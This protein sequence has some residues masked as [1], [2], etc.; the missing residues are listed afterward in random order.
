MSPRNT[1]IFARKILWPG[2]NI[3]NRHH[4]L[5]TVGFRQGTL[6]ISERGLERATGAWTSV[7]PRPDDPRA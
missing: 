3:R 4:H 1:C 5:T 2:W 7:P 6:G